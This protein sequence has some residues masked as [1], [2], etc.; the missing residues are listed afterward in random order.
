M[1]WKVMRL[2]KMLQA[3]RACAYQTFSSI[4][5]LKT[6]AK[7]TENIK[8]DPTT[9]QRTKFSIHPI[10]TS[11]Y[12]VNSTMP[13]SFRVAA[14]SLKATR[15]GFSVQHLQTSLHFKSEAVLHVTDV[16]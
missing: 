4:V 14:S 6:H 12:G 8:N 3:I 15:R 9:K 11:L 1:D 13:S 10:S 16:M 7:I 2:K 5:K